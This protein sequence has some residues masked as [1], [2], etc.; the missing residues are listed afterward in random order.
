M[1]HIQTLSGAGWSVGERNRAGLMRRGTRDGGRAG[2][3]GDTD[4]PLVDIRTMLEM[5]HPN[6]SGIGIVVRS[7]KIGWNFVI[8]RR[9]L[10]VLVIYTC[11]IRPKCLTIDQGTQET[12]SLHWSNRWGSRSNGWFTFAESLSPYFVTAE[13]WPS[14]L[15][16]T[17]DHRC[18]VWMGPMRFPLDGSTKR[19]LG[20]TAVRHSCDCGCM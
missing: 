19:Y 1:L 20:A 6:D 14:T 5:S 17:W 11:I 2:D 7:L 15:Q 8:L 12:M 18:R 3:E 4:T 16:Y 10:Y 13:S 9:E